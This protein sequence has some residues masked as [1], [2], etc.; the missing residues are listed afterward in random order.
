MCIVQ[1]LR[2]MENCCLMER[3]QTMVLL[4]QKGGNYVYNYM[5]S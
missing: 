3:M 4:T 1:Y 2:L 5:D